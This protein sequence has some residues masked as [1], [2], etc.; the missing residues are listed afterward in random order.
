MNC[1]VRAAWSQAEEISWVVVVGGGVRVGGGLSSQGPG[2]AVFPVWPQLG[3]PPTQVADETGNAGH[4]DGTRCA[5][6]QGWGG[7]KQP[8]REGG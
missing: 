3:E 6:S 2:V 4:G 8:L 7:Q 5:G 1:P